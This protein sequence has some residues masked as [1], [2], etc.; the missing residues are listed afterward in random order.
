LIFLH[1]RG[2]G[3]FRPCAACRVGGPG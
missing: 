1:I 3:V 2:S